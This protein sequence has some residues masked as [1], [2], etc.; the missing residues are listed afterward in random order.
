MKSI[1]VYVY[2][3]G[4]NMSTYCSRRSSAMSRRSEFILFHFS[5]L[6]F[7]S[8][9]VRVTFTPPS[10]A[11]YALT[12]EALDDHDYATTG[13]YNNRVRVLSKVPKRT[14]AR[15]RH[16]Y[17]IASETVEVVRKITTR[18]YYYTR[19]CA[20][21]VRRRIPTTDAIIIIIIIITFTYLLYRYHCAAAICATMMHAARSCTIIMVLLL[22]FT[23]S[24]RV[25]FR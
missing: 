24:T 7:T 23:Y 12:E 17:I 4:I 11:L 13:V 16:H 18:K 20:C 5:F 15:G 19:L 3:V 21:V 10:N 25:S 2:H 6:F 1:I 14:C 22:L 9:L 8:T